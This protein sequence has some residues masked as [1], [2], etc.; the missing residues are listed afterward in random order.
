MRKSRIE[1]MDAVRAFACLSVLGY[2]MYLFNFGHLGVALFFVMSGFLLVYNHFDSFDTEHITLKSC[3]KFSYNKITKLYPLYFVMLLIP[4]AGQVYG[5]ANGLTGWRTVLAKLVTNALL[6]QSWIPINDFYFA[7]NGPAWYLSS[8]AL[9]YFV[10][11]YIL[12]GIRKLQSNR[13]ALVA[14]ILIW[15]AQIIVGYAGESIYVKLASPDSNMR[16]DFVCWFTY[17]SPVFRLGDFAT[18]GLLA[19]IFMRATSEHY[20]KLG[21]TVAEVC[22]IILLALIQVC[23]EMQILP[24]NDTAA[25]LPCCAAL[26]YT[27]AM[28]RGYISKFLTNKAVK[29]IADISSEVFLTHAVVIFVCTP[30]IERLPLGAAEKRAVYIAGVLALTFVAATLGRRFNNAINSKRKARSAA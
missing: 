26:I 16:R 19:Y 18:G 4:F 2:H 1:S 21:W 24:I 17:I 23:F 11:P 12:C 7:L 25:Y 22:S 28:N 30:I 14:V 5:A 8:I 3:I 13:A 6:V 20:S 10:F 29:Y 9:A 15:L 27:F